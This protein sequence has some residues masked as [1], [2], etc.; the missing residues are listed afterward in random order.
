MCGDAE[1]SIKDE[2]QRYFVPQSARHDAEP[3]IVDGEMVFDPHNDSLPDVFC[4][5]RLDLWDVMIEQLVLAVDLYP[6][7]Q[8]AA[9]FKNEHS[10]PLPP[11][12]THKPFEKLKAL[13]SEKKPKI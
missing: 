5:T 1:N 4:G 11:V 3:E 12:E 13:I 9:S 6:R 8:K 7:S 2:F 10:N